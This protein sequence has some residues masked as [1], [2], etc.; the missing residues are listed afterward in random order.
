TTTTAENPTPGSNGST[1]TTTT[2]NKPGLPNTGER[3]SLIVSV[4]GVA[5]LIVAVGTVLHYRKK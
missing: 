5:M 4:A 3:N 2:G 1:T